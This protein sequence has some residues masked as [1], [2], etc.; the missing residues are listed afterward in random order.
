MYLYTGYSSFVVFNLSLIIHDLELSILIF[1]Q[2][3]KFYNNFTMIR[4][5]NVIDKDYTTLN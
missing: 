5:I 2:I 3:L 1:H 4:I